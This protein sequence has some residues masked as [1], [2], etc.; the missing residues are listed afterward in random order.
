[1]HQIR[2][3]EFTRNSGVPMY[4]W[5]VSD[6]GGCCVGNTVRQWLASLSL[7]KITFSTINNHQM[8]RML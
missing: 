4:M 8:C 2:H 5:C 1:M 3:A 6:G 7:L